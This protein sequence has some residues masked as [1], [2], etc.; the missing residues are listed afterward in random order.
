MHLQSPA[1]VG[2]VHWAASTHGCLEKFYLCGGI[3]RALGTLGTICL[4]FPYL[5]EIVLLQTASQWQLPLSFL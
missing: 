5:G 1:Y 3:F 2:M 4:V